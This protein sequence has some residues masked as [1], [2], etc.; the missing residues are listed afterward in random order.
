M[1]PNTKFLTVP[2]PL[3]HQEFPLPMR[4]LRVFFL[5][6]WRNDDLASVR[7]SG[8]LYGQ[9]TQEPNSVQAIRLGTSGAAG[10]QYAG[11]L[12]NV[13]DHAVRNQKSVQPK[14]IPPGLKTADDYRSRLIWRIQ[15][16]AQ[17]SD[18][19][20]QSSAVTR[21][22]P[23]KLSFVALGRAIPDDP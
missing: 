9:D 2:D 6:R 8:N 10:H 1:A 21:L 5:R 11:R 7:I 17:A 15:P 12:D 3:L 13:V 16:T 22:K 14:S 4:S 20:K 18:E 23:M 19:S